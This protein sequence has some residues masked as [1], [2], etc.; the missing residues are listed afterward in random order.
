MGS[1]WLLRPDHQASTEKS[2]S[3]EESF[4]DVEPHK[5][6]R[7]EELSLYVWGDV[8]MRNTLRDRNRWFTAVAMTC[9][10]GFALCGCTSRS[11][12]LSSNLPES[13]G[14]DAIEAERH[15]AERKR[16]ET[17]VLKLKDRSATASHERSFSPQATASLDQGD[18]S[19]AV[20]IAKTGPGRA[21]RDLHNLKTAGWAGDSLD[22]RVQPVSDEQEGVVDTAKPHS[23]SLKREPV[24]TGLFDEAE[25]EATVRVQKPARPGGPAATHTPSENPKSR[26]GRAS[27][28]DVSEHP[29][30]KQAPT[31]ARSTEPRRS[32]AKVRLDDQETSPETSD[33][34]TRVTTVPRTAK[35]KTSVAS[36]PQP[37]DARQVEAK[38]RVRMLLAQAKSL[39]N[40]GEFRSAYRVS[41]L[42]QRIAD[43]EDL[44]FVAGEEQPTDIV[45]SILMKVRS[46]EI[47]Q[48][49]TAHSSVDK[50][51]PV[52]QPVSRQTE[53]L[54]LE[55][56]ASTVTIDNPWEESATESS[57]KPP[58]RIKPG[59]SSRGSRLNP[60][61][62]GSR[63]QWR[64]AQNEPLDRGH[65]AGE[66]PPG[67][68][69]AKD[70]RRTAEV[71]P[72][73]KAAVSST[74]L[75]TAKA[76]AA[77]TPGLVPGQFPSKSQT[78]AGAL[79]SAD[80][81][82]TVP[83][84]LAIAQNWR[85]QNLNDVATDRM[86]LLV[87]PLPPQEP[88][89]PD[90]LGVDVDDTFATDIQE[91]SPVQPESKLWMILAAAAGAFAMLFVR[92]RPAAVVR[93]V[94]DGK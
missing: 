69:T 72:D 71:V 26:P 37:E 67:I 45:R 15:V 43:S 28:D 41:L 19:E 39:V 66:M 30:A 84:P 40:K 75:P 56:P 29:W 92:R 89:I 76:P 25:D 36:Q 58:M 86:P 38:A 80:S 34:P 47:Q 57:S 54:P 70:G 48:A 85:D 87:A 88:L 52:A 10:S 42:A 63:P 31:T 9:L 22:R 3:R 55:E 78:P 81:P 49:S 8:S 5:T 27:F 62:P 24:A 79:M 73:D 11:R 65:S 90:A 82:P 64:N 18:E 17:G 83:S 74:G 32:A 6:I 77:Q 91:P 13:A 46:E 35:T 7:R 14:R 21:P 61:F 20:A 16:Q 60:E 44:F 53:G 2:V 1:W 51:H 94:G 4:H 33:S 93:S 12:D 23:E 59:P 50:S 68:A